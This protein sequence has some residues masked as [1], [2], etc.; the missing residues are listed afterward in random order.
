MQ[1]LNLQIAEEEKELQIPGVGGSAFEAAAG[2]LG[3][4]RSSAS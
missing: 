2:L 1:M 3:L 4:L